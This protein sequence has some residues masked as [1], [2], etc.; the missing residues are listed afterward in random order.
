M[1]VSL[2][3]F[4]TLCNYPDHKWKKYIKFSLTILNYKTLAD[5]SP[6][7]ELLPAQQLHEESDPANWRRHINKLV[8]QQRSEALGVGEKTLH[9]VKSLH[10]LQV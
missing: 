7:C 1:D 6:S 8:K 3:F 9:S 5:T 10:S 4:K 2:L